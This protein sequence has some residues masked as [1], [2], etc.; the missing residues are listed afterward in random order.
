MT[1][2]IFDSIIILS[3]DERKVAKKKK[4]I[5]TNKNTIK[6]WDTYVDNIGI[7][8]LIETNNK[9]KYLIRYLDEVIRALVLILPKIS[10]YVKTFKEIIN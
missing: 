2:Q 3:F 5:M 8:K 10:G 6:I 9:S 7:S 1:T 4:K